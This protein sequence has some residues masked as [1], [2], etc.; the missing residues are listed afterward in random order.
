MSISFRKIKTRWTSTEIM[1]K[2]KVALSCNKLSKTH[3]VALLTLALFSVV[4]LISVN[5]L[6]TKGYEIKELE[7]DIAAQKKENE[8]LQLGIIEKQSMASL[9]KKIAELGLVSA[10]SVQYIT[11]SA[12][13]A[14]AEPESIAQ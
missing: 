6:A 7:R 1:R 2:Q 3:A 9:Q 13:V 4:Y 14:V 5:A 11:P 8:R 10:D 12:A